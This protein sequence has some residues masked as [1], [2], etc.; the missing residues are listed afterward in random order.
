[1]PSMSQRSNRQVP[2]TVVACL[3]ALITGTT[4]RTVCGDE[5]PPAPSEAVLVWA[6]GDRLPGRL[7]SIADGRVRWQ[8]PVFRDPLDIRATALRAVQRPSQPPSA[9]PETMRVEL[10]GG[11]QLHGELIGA[12]DDTYVFESAAHGRF[13]VRRSHVRRLRRRR[14]EDLVY[15]GPRGLA[16]WEPLNSQ[17]PVSHWSD[18]AD[19]TLS[20][21]RRGAGL[22]LPVPLPRRCEIELRV[23]STQRCSFALG[24]RNVAR[25]LRVETW[26]DSLVAARGLEFQELRTLDDSDRELQLTAWVDLDAGRLIASDAEGRRLAEF[27]FRDGEGESTGI[28]ISNRDG[29]LTLD[30][31]RISHWDGTPPPDVSDVADR[32]ILRDGTTRPGRLMPFSDDQRLVRVDTP[33]DEAPFPLADVSEVCHLTRADTRDEPA[34]R[35]RTRSGETI[36]ADDVRCDQRELQVRSDYLSEPLIVPQSDLQELR[37]TADAADS[38][39]DDVLTTGG[40][41]LHG[42]V[43]IVEGTADPLQWQP[44][45]A[46]TPVVLSRSGDAGFRRRHAVATAVDSTTFPHVLHLSNGD[47]LP[48]RIHQASAG[49]WQITSP[50]CDAATIAGDRV[51]AAELSAGGIRR[52]TRFPESDWKLDKAAAGADDARLEVQPG[53]GVFSSRL[54][55]ADTVRFRLD[56]EDN[57]LCVLGVYCTRS[58]WQGV[59][60]DFYLVLQQGSV[61]VSPDL[62][63]VPV[64]STAGRTAATENRVVLPPETRAAMVRI[65]LDARRLVVQ[66]S[67]QPAATLETPFAGAAFPGFGLRD[68]GIGVARRAQTRNGMIRPG[69]QAPIIVS[70]FDLTSS[71][72]TSA[73]SA[74]FASGRSM[75]VT[76]PRF[77]RDRPPT[78]VLLAPQGDLLRGTLQSFDGESVGFESRLERITIPHDRVAAIFCLQSP[79]AAD[80][81]ARAEGFVRVELANGYS[82]SLV[83]DAAADGMLQGRA[84]A[85]G[86][87]TI[88]VDQIAAL[89]IGD[90][91]EAHVELERG[92]WT[93]R[94]VP[95]PS[96]GQ[97]LFSS[98]GS[99]AKSLIGERLPELKL[100]AL[101]GGDA[102]LSEPRDQVILLHFWT[103]WCRPCRETLPQ[104]QTLASSFP[105]ESVVL[106]G[107]NL[108]DDAVTIRRFLNAHDIDATVVR[109]VDG[110]AARTVRL[111][112]IPWTAVI[113]PGGLVTDIVTGHDER[114]LPSLRASVHEAL[115]S[116]P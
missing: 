51:L 75:I 21:N 58:D 5:S 98:E 110:S 67:D 1:M 116:R 69:A 49:A 82:V 114:T 8:S 72:M 20:T 53:G 6:N 81:A 13:R 19:G 97:M 87:L 92:D 93:V 71:P 15:S 90:S 104:L 45:G 59:P 83:P 95:D 2:F 79:D 48:C 88:P 34:I 74:L 111:S 28:S 109:D 38:Q 94:D 10:R 12:T 11:G 30:A 23:R 101:D 43:V 55:A 115:Q 84:P 14:P 102:T 66:V 112:G 77:R 39:A 61:S 33:T 36:P 24:L 41:R 91:A 44:Q 7:L 63:S 35:I 47:T 80:G 42:Q 40:M 60:P 16:D 22:F 113:A 17:N 52:Q 86:R 56:W 46:D 65:R 85:L 57:S 25:G 4:D 62:Q 70:D 106:T 96:W 54:I 89:A 107:V 103:T 3:C 9:V 99:D 100:T 31:L 64:A 73:R 27:R 18:N 50:F 29:D 26:S 76:I 32:V 105:N 78:H 108:Q 68:L 37:W